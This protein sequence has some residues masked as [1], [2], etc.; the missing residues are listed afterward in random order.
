MLR[1][2]NVKRHNYS[3][4]VAVMWRHNYSCWEVVMWRHNYS[5]WEVVMWRHNYSC[6]VAVTCIFYDCRIIGCCAMIYKTL[7]FLLSWPS[8]CN[9][10]HKIKYFLMWKIYIHLISLLASHLH[11]PHLTVFILLSTNLTEQLLQGSG[12]HVASG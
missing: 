6:W 5:C 12:I 4:W 1:G 11:V 8:H 9:D 3:C 7:E 10:I 2:C